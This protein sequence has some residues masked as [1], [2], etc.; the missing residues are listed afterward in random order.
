MPTYLRNLTGLIVLTTQIFVMAN[1]TCDLEETVLQVSLKEAAPFSMQVAGKWQGI[2]IDLWKEVERKLT[3]N[4][5]ASRYQ[6]YESIEDVLNSVKYDQ[7]NNVI[8]IGAITVTAARELELNFTHPYFQ[9]TLGVAVTKDTDSNLD[10]LIGALTSSKF[11]YAVGVLFG[12]LLIVGFLIWLAERL[13]VG[14]DFRST[15]KGIGDGFWWSAVTMTT[16]GY[17][18]KTPR[19]LVGRAIALVWMFLSIIAVASLTGTIASSFTIE[20]LSVIS[21]LDDLRNKQVVTVGLTNGQ[22]AASLFLFDQGL[23]FRSVPT[24]TDAFSHLIEGNADAIVYDTPVLKHHIA[25]QQLY[26][27]NISL[28]PIEYQP[29][30]YAFAISES[31]PCLENINRAILETLESPKWQMK[32]KTL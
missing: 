7:E 4:S 1:E 11:W 31:N 14:S 19:S 17:G 16:V 2:S 28:L 8:A 21:E 30:N 13:S 27:S 32:L 18:D 5:I 15:T 26:E 24:L 12:T 23:K 6:G 9:T 10:I 20:R 3:Q 22:S 25:S 29:A